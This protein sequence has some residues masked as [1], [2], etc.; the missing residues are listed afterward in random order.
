MVKGKTGYKDGQKG[1]ATRKT[2]EGVGGQ[3][4][5]NMERQ[6]G[7]GARK[8]TV[9]GEVAGP[10]GRLHGKKRVARE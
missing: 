5:S 10:E 7:M 3:V 9:E 6:P 8:M 2:A 1:D 4:T